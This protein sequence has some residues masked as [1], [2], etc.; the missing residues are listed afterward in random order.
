MQW[1]CRPLLHKYVF[2]V[3]KLRTDGN[4]T[5]SAISSCILKKKTSSKQ[6]WVETVLV[7]RMSR[8]WVNCQFRSL[9]FLACLSMKS[10]KARPFRT[11]L[12]VWFG[13]EM[14]ISCNEIWIQGGGTACMFLQTHCSLIS[15]ANTWI[16]IKMCICYCH[17]AFVTVHVEVLDRVQNSRWFSFCHKTIHI[18]GKGGIDWKDVLGLWLNCTWLV[19]WLTNCLAVNWSRVN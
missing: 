17:L 14:P 5:F 2:E 11:W 15:W 8:K 10:S 1:K 13:I 6:L 9:W 19:T 4:T 7:R 16:S 3:A 12:L 18:Q